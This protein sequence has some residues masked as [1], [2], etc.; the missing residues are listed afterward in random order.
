MAETNLPYDPTDK[1]SIVTYAKRLVG[2]SLRQTTDMGRI[3]SPQTRRGS[4]GNAIEEHYFK[5][6]PNSDSAPDFAEVGLELKVT[7]MKKA[8]GGLVAKE[9]LV[10]SMIDFDEVV[11]EDFEHSHFLKKASDILLISYLW[12][13][14]KDP[15]DYTVQ[16]VEEW[17][18][19]EQDLVQIKQD[20]ET[21]VGKV[22]LGRAH[23]ISGSDTMYLEACT[24][25]A[26]STIRRHQPYSDK[27]AKPRAWAF[28][29]AYMTAVEGHL[30][31]RTESIERDESERNL[32]L[33]DLVR[34]RFS[35]FFGLSEAELSDM[36]ELTK[37]KNLCARITRNI[38][39]VSEDARIEEFEKAGIKPKTMR[40]RAN[41]KPKEAL[42]FPMFDYY[43][44]EA[45]DFEDSEFYEQL[46]QKYLF[47]LFREDDSGVYRLWDVCFWQM[48]ES[49]YPEARRCY[50]QMQ[51]NV[52]AGHA[53]ISVRSS[54]N[55]CCH[56][57]PHAR[58]ASDVI[59][60][61]HGNPTV[62]KCFWLNQAYLQEEIA[63]TLES[64]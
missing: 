44:L 30:F 15:L 57:R 16:L 22:R 34:S 28:K 63:K 43:T 2:K 20:W 31:A 58:D 3:E 18:I 7:P 50:D 40:L 14:D 51:A 6:Q 21:V 62:K 17:K 53:E 48:P 19:P 55:R 61:P 4:Y 24:K 33:L 46:Q 38:L 45:C 23:E 27:P 49:D 9:R 11:N 35:R 37:S 32:A 29:A 64:R 13:Q 56:V 36:F 1:T 10:I 8:K 12:E 39:G 47:V 59:P 41:G 60:Q 54:E 25:A 26:N 52:K 5:Y 42:S